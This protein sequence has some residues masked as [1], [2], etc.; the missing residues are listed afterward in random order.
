MSEHSKLPDIVRLRD[1]FA[2]AKDAIEHIQGALRHRQQPQDVTFH[3]ALKALR[4]GI[5]LSERL[6]S[7][8]PAEETWH[9]AI[10]AAATL[11]LTFP[12]WWNMSAGY[13]AVTNEERAKT[14]RALARPSTP[15]EEKKI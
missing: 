2:E 5:E 6:R 11:M 12:E 14:I 1:Y 10:E 3:R 15:A 13:C 9:E 7:S 8:A 4:D